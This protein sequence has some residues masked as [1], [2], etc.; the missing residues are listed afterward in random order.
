VRYC[1]TFG[2]STLGVATGSTVQSA[3]FLAPWDLELGASEISVVANGIASIPAPIS[4]SQFKIVWPHDWAYW[5]RL[6]GSLADG[7]LWVLGP[8]G[9]IP[10]DPW[11]PKYR[12]QAA[13]VWKTLRH[14]IGELQQIGNEIHAQRLRQAAEQAGPI[15]IE[16]GDDEEEEQRELV[17]IAPIKRRAAE[18]AHRKQQSK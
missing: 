7:D 11:G 4:V 5:A 13:E 14:S 3:N 12:D 15:I 1:R 9:P 8:N 16:H 10:V 18:P 17:D 6:I 2:F